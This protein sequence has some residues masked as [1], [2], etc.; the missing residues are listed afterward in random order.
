MP[1]PS[2]APSGFLLCDGSSGLPE[3]N[4]LSNPSPA[5]SSPTQSTV[6]G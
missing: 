2:P 6:F 5:E 1:G 3:S 4:A